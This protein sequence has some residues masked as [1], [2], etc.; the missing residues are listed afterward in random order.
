MRFGTLLRGGGWLATLL[1]A[2]VLAPLP[3]TPSARAQSQPIL[4]VAPLAAPIGVGEEAPFLVRVSGIDHAAL[5]LRYAV[6]GGV[7]VGLLAPAQVGP[8]TF[9]AVAYVRR[10]IPGTV[11]LRVSLGE[12]SASASVEAI[13]AGRVRVRLLVQDVVEGAS[14]TW[15]FE[16]VDTAGVVVDRVNVAASGGFPGFADTILLPYGTYTVRQILGLDTGL[17]CEDG[18][19][20]AVRQPPGAVLTVGVRGPRSEVEFVVDVCPTIAPPPTASPT[21]TPVEAVAGE[22]TPGPAPTPRPPAAGTGVAPAPSGERLFSAVV[23]VGAILAGGLALAV[24]RV[25]P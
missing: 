16:V 11:T 23:G 6:E 10:D 21:P 7:L 1:A 13:L 14:R 18:R 3:L 2:V 24:R 19:F 20:F 12:L 8:S 25:R 9:E 5:D 4:S 15:P 17:E 22:R